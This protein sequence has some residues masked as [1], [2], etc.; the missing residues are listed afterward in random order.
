MS[1]N[2]SQRRDGS[3]IET[4][5]LIELPVRDVREWG[6]LFEPPT[7]WKVEDALRR[8]LPSRRWFGGKA[9]TVERASIVDVVPM[10][11]TGDELPVHVVLLDVEYEGGTIETYICP[12]AMAT[13]A[14]AKKIRDQSPEAIIASLKFAGASTEAVL[15]DALIDTA[16]AGRLLDSMRRSDRAVG[17]HGELV[18]D[19]T[20]VLHE[21]DEPGNSLAPRLSNAEQSNSAILYGDQLIL[22]L[23]RKVE[24]GINPD[25]EIGRFLLDHGFKN[26]A[27]VAGDIHYEC[28]D[29]EPMTV[30]LLQKFVPN[31]GTGWQHALEVLHYQF[32][33]LLIEKPSRSELGETSLGR[34][35]LDVWKEEAPAS[36][37]HFLGDYL[38]YAER[39][40]RRTAELHA[41]LAS[42]RENP[43]FAPE[44]ISLAYQH[45]LH[46]SIHE[47]TSAHV[48]TLRSRLNDVD[49]ETR[50][51]A[52]RL[53]QQEG[54][55]LS[56]FNSVQ[57]QTLAGSRIRCH[58]DY[59][60]G[61]V[62]FAQDDYVIIDFEGEPARPLNE[63]RQKHSPLLD[64][65][66]MLRSYDYAAAQAVRRLGSASHLS[67]EEQRTLHAAARAWYRW[68]GAAFLRGYFDRMEGASLLPES[69]DELRV[70]M[71]ALL[72]EKGMYEVA[73]ELN[74]RPDWV[75]VPLHGVL[76]ILEAMH[77]VVP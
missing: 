60:L 27:P 31:E 58:G 14:A 53:L 68:N 33:R 11:G 59:H 47:K 15:F 4:T 26:T 28:A 6:K 23:F 34:T 43:S 74:N 29:A 22:K 49:S 73:Y 37:R 50:I 8:Y 24:A 18:F 64:I 69:H 61:Q 51:D 48:R 2:T 30:G 13:D 3:L 10:N 66:G 70:L 65:A 52:E 41:T 35:P 44:P 19:G 21:V 25:L 7:Q 39:L 42:D 20:K 16:F 71:N 77:C 32:N 57:E 75:A 62:L 1:A 76:E 72:L 56:C 17:K 67:S 36:V 46:R 40:G 38:S 45:A 54:A 55:L 9:R 5:D 12:L 63:R